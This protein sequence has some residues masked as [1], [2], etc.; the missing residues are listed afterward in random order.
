MLRRAHA[1]AQKGPGKFIAAFDGA[2]GIGTGD[3][4]NFS[5]Y[6][7]GLGEGVNRYDSGI[8]QFPVSGAVDDAMQ[9][10][11][12]NPDGVILATGYSSGGADAI[13][14]VTALSAEGISVKTLV[15]FDPRSGNRL[16]GASSYAIPSN[17]R[18]F[19]FYQR[20][21]FSLSPNTF[22]GAA[23]NGAMA[24]NVNLTGIA[25]HTNIVGYVR[26]NYV[27]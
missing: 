5:A 12:E 11:A 20:G 4:A 14:F 18:A 22:K 7:D 23:L 13:K 21:R 3:N 9:F 16:I 27:Q 25:N 6:V 1:F 10:I 26:R 17:V 8:G 2:G 15:T 19:N 24:T